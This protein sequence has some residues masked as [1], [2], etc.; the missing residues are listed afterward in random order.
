MNKCQRAT[1]IISVLQCLSFPAHGQI[2]DSTFTSYDWI[3]PSVISAKSSHLE[4]RGD[5]SYFN[6]SSV[7]LHEGASLDALLVEIPGLLIDPKGNVSVNGRP[8]GWD[9]LTFT[10]TSERRGFKLYE[11][12]A[13]YFIGRLIIIL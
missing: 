7:L 12:N 1:A 4:V 11:G 13:T 10:T 5:T 2:P 9:N 3:R 8:S 6:P